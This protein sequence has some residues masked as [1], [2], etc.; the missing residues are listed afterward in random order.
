MAEG[1]YV[2]GTPWPWQ[3][4]LELLNLWRK[5][6]VSPPRNDTDVWLYMSE[7]IL[8]SSLLSKV[9]PVSNQVLLCY[10]G[11]LIPLRHSLII[12][13]KRLQVCKI[14]SEQGCNPTNPCLMVNFL[15]ISRFY[16]CAWGTKLNNS[17]WKHLK[18]I[19]QL[20]EIPAFSFYSDLSFLANFAL[21]N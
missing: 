5:L 3:G 2:G 7:T 17:C 16:F 4:K 9:P 6:E 20:V 15:A 11:L 18:T 21:H 1:K 19:Q 14:P 13:A 8:L 12:I 10:Q